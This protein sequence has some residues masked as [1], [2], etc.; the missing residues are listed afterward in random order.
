MATKPHRNSQGNLNVLILCVLIWPWVCGCENDSER[1]PSRRPPSFGAIAGQYRGSGSYVET[2]WESAPR[3]NLAWRAEFAQQ[4]ES[5]FV[6]TMISTF[7]DP[8]ITLTG[9]SMQWGVKGSAGRSQC[10]TIEETSMVVPESPGWIYGDQQFLKMFEGCTVSL[11]GDSIFY[12]G[13]NPECER[14][15]LVRFQ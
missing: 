1:I 5:T 8:K 2:A 7:T 12:N 10:V 3:L 15:V 14:F 13:P 4:T 9:E 6:G 11:K